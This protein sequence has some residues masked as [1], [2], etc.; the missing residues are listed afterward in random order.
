MCAVHQVWRAGGDGDE[1]RAALIRWEA[2]FKWRAC[3]T[4][5]LS[6]HVKGE[7]SRWGSGLEKQDGCWGGGG[8]ILSEQL[9]FID[10]QIGEKA[11]KKTALWCRCYHWICLISVDITKGCISG[12]WRENKP[13]SLRLQSDIQGHL[14]I[15]IIASI[16]QDETFLLNV[17]SFNIKDETKKYYWVITSQVTSQ[18]WDVN[19]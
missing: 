12:K 3:F 2:G 15:C 9:T 14:N 1:R 7:Q 18:S 11:H 8:V 4:L 13:N 6:A 10:S 16:R 5:V 17:S 19:S